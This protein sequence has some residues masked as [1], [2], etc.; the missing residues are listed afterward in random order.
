LYSPKEPHKKAIDALQKQID[1]HFKE[2]NRLRSA[3][4]SHVPISSLSAEHLSEVFLCIVESSLLVVRDDTRFVCGTFAFRQVCKHWNEVAVGFPRLWVWWV[5]TA[6]RVW[7]LFDA[8]SKDT[9]ISLTWRSW[10]KTAA[11]T[12]S[13]IL[14]DLAIPGRVRTLNFNGTSNDLEEFLGNFG[15]S[16]SSIASSIRLH[17]TP[18]DEQGTRERTAAFLSLLFPKLSKLDINFLPDSSSPILTTSN[19]VSLKLGSPHRCGSHYT[20]PQFSHI[21]ERHSN[22]QELH[23]SQGGI[24]QVKPSGPSVPVFLPRLV[25]LRLYG[26]EAVITGFIGLVSM[27]SPLHNVTIHFEST[28]TSSIP[29]LAGTVKKILTPYY[30]CQGLEYPRKV[31]N[32]TISK[33][34]GRSLV[35]NVGS[36]STPA[37]RPTANLELQFNKVDN[38]LAQKICLLFPLDDVFEFALVGLDL[39]RSGCRKILQKMD[40]LS[41]LRLSGLDIGPVLGTLNFDCELWSMP[42][43]WITYL[44]IDELSG[45]SAP[46]LNSLSLTNLNIRPD[47]DRKLVNIL[48]GGD[49]E[50]VLE[51]LVVRSCSVHDNSAQWRFRKLVERVTWESVSL[52]HSDISDD[53]GSEEDPH[54][55]M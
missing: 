17:V 16:H 15:S 27:S 54:T 6:T 55:C 12:Q 50:A 36:H 31:N 39:P 2:I 8:R 18:Y 7:P 43:Y 14:T 37:S 47:L 34:G 21:L 20:L 38:V 24:P 41:H 1:L 44:C 10:S 25:D 33:F 40:G 46:K 26:P 19:L 49:G 22:L 3:Q 52:V 23:L 45:P 4:N 9:P 29:A 48:D 51:N 11:L 28:P 5:S 53:E 35:F 30:K 42:R 32:L 13:G